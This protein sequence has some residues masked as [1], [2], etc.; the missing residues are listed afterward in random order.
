M[1]Q[2]RNTMALKTQMVE[3]DIKDL[4][5]ADWNYKTDGTDE[6]IDKLIMNNTLKDFLV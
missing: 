6:Q 5:K 1:E 4:I 3:M 2:E